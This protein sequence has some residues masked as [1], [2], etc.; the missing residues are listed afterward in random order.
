MTDG[1]A[2]PTTTSP[3]R[4]ATD[5]DVVVIGSGFAGLYALH[6]LRNGLG[7]DVRSFDDADGVGGTWYWNRYPGVR[8]DTEVTAYCY[9]FDRELFDEW[10]WGDPR[11]QCPLR[12]VR[13]ALEDHHQRRRA[14]LGPVPRDGC[15]PAL[16]D[17]LSEHP[18][19]GQLRR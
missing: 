13:G 2:S 5:V 9:S 8:C 12:R 17:E 10:R 11:R 7:L 3:D 14:P 6:K 1:T 18:R 4:G 19:L 16:L 15:R